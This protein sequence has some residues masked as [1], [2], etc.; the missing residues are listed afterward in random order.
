MRIS[1]QAGENQEEMHEAVEELLLS[2]DLNAP[3]RLVELLD[4]E[5]TKYNFFAEISQEIRFEYTQ[6]PAVLTLS[7]WSAE[8]LKLP[9]VIMEPMHD[10]KV[11]AIS[12]NSDWKNLKREIL[13]TTPQNPVFRYTCEISLEE[14]TKAVQI[15]GR[16]IWSGDEKPQYKGV[17]GKIMDV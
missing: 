3:D 16:T 6:T 2:E 13:K 17:F 11:L 5:R 4:Y 15:I 12:G 10:E 9:E 7:A 1:A 8:R 14:E